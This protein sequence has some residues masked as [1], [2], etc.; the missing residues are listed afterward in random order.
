MLSKI[1]SE[2]IKELFNKKKYQ[3][4]LLKIYKKI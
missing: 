3:D 1:F 2:N 4:E